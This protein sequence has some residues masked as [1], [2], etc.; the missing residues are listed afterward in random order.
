[1]R[2]TSDTEQGETTKARILHELSLLSYN[3]TSARIVRLKDI[4]TS[5]FPFVALTPIPVAIVFIEL[6]ALPG[7][8]AFFWIAIVLSTL[9]TLFL[10]FSGYLMLYSLKGKPVREG[11][12]AGKDKG[13][14]PVQWESTVQLY[15]AL[16]NAQLFATQ[17]LEDLLND[18]ERLV[19]WVW[20]MVLGTFTVF[21]L[22]LIFGGIA[23]I[24]S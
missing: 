14:D 8:S 17:D 7:K 19:A 16:T 13:Y 20:R 10:A 2:D 21:V 12:A 11:L 22:Y 1:M 9:Y 5:L 3:R 15:K 6:I 23:I 18:R 24:T 4:V